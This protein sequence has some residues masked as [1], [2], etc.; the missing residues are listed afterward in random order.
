MIE[1]KK[2]SLKVAKARLIEAVRSATPRVVK[3]YIKRSMPSSLELKHV[4]RAQKKILVMLAAD[5]GN[6][7]DVAITYAQHKWLEKNFPE[8]RVIEVPISQTYKAMRKLKRVVSNDD[9]VTI[10]GGGNMGDMFEGIEEQRRFIVKMFKRNQIIS[11]PQ[12]IDFSNTA[13]GK[14][15]LKRTQK[16]YNSHDNLTLIARETNSYNT[17]KQLFTAKI[18]L[19]PDIVLSLDEYSGRQSEQ[20]R[21]NKAVICIRQDKE[22]ILSKQARNDMLEVLKSKYKE[23]AYRDTHIGNVILT[24]DSRMEELESIWGEFQSADLVITD[25]LHGMIF[26]A[27]TGTPCIALN[28]SNGKVRGVYDLWVKRLNGVILVKN[29]DNDSIEEAMAGLKKQLP[30]STSVLRDEFRTIKDITQGNVKSK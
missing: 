24:E 8:Y 3:H 30:K 15:S 11:F 28:N 10:V 5:Y 16:A 23:V 4:E 29:V 19:T 9:I 27:I 2:E 12:T 18:L 1:Q 22:S 20:R 7:G 21:K 17:M 25:R 6:L 14:I 26:C 13:K